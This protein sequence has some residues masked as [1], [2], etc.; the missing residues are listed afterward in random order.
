MFEAQKQDLKLDNT[1]EFK[2]LAITARC[3]EELDG[4]RLSQRSRAV[5][6]RQT[7]HIK[8]IPYQ[9]LHLVTAT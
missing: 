5:K 4:N 7:N 8:K 3:R 1:A 6:G 9:D 2:G